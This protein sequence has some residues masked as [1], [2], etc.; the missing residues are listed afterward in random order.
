[1]YKRIITSILVI[2]LILMS[3]TTAYATPPAHPHIGSGT[4]ADGGFYFQYY[5]SSGTWKDLNTPPH[6]VIETSEVA[7]CVDHKADSPSGNETYSAFNPQSLY[8]PTTYYGLLAILKAGYPYK[9][10]GLSAIQARYA[11]ANAIR[12]WL[13][14]SAGIGYN[15][16]NL[17]RG[18]VRPKSGQQP[19]YDFMVALVD[20]AR[21][22]EQPVFSI[23]TNP[24]NIK[25]SYQGNQLLGQFKIVFSNINGYYSID[26]SKLPSGVTISGYTGNNGDVLTISAPISYAGRTVALNNIFE[27]HDTRA[28]SNMYWF[29]PNGNEQPVLVPVTDTTKPVVSGSMIF[30]SDALGYIEIIKT[31]ADSGT[32]LIGAVFKILNSSGNEVARLTTNAQGYAKSSGLP[33][34]TYKLQEVTAPAS[35]L[36][37]TTVHGN[38]SVTS[39]NT[40]TVN[41]TNE[42]P[43]GIIRIT[44]TNGNADMGDYSLEGA[45]FSISNARKTVVE[46]ITTDAQGHANSSEL[47][48]GIYT[49]KEIGAPYGFTLNNTEFTASL[50]YESPTTAIVYDDINV[51]EQPQSGNIRITKV[52]ANP[53]MGDYPLAGAVFEVRDDDEDTVAEITTDSNG[54][55][56]TGYL[57]LGEY[58][59]IETAAPFGYILNDEV[60]TAELSY[61]GQTVNVVYGDIEVNELPQTGTITITKRDSETG[62]V[63]QGDASLNSAIFD[64]YNSDGERVEK[65]DCGDTYKATSQPL[66]L[67]TYMIKEVQAPAGYLLNDTAYSIEIVYS[68]QNVDVNHKSYI[69]SNDVIK[70][71]IA[72]TKFADVALAEWNTDNPKPPLENVEFEIRLKSTGDLVDTLT[73]DSDGKAL[74]IMLPYGTYSVTETRT[75]LGFIVCDHFEVSIEENRKVYSYIVENEVYKSKVK[76]IKVDS[77]TGET[78]P[79]AGTEFQIRDASGDLIVQTVTYPQEKQIGTFITDETGTLTLPEPLIFGDYT[80]HEVKAPYGYWLDETPLAFSIDDSGEDLVTIEFSDEIIQKRIRIIKTDARDDERILAGA[81]F[82]VYK[83][84]DLV[85]TITANENGYAETKLL[86]VGEYKV[87]E[88]EAPVGFVLED[89]SFKV[90]INNDDTMVYTFEC[91]NNPTE[92]TITKTDISDGTL[93]P[94]AHI[95]LYDVNE[96]LV[97]EGDTDENGELLIFELP[98]GKYTFKETIAPVGYVLN[99]KVFEFEILE[100]GDIVGAT[101]IENITTEVTLSKFDLVDGRPVANA[102]IEILNEDGQIVFTDK[103]DQNGEITVTHLL[104][105]T[106]TFRE[107]QAPD[108]YIL[109]VEEVKFSIDEYGDITGETEM[110]NSPTMLEINKVIYETNE[111]LTGAGFRVKNFLGLNTLHFIESED[112]SY[113]FYKDGDI[114]E[115]MVDENGQAIIYGLPL[116][117]YWLEEATVPE[118]YYPTAPVKVTIGG[119][120]N[121]EVPYEA[122]IPNSVFEKLGLDRDK[123]NVPIAIGATALIIGCTTVMVLKRRKKRRNK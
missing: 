93:L 73:T 78:I 62:D 100:N 81:V 98:V 41:L 36:L 83:G 61:A 11:T 85:D 27:A 122:V 23:S 18:Y 52:N 45:Q 97:Y 95:E 58:S 5:G 31:D 42:Q 114:T 68:N 2:I 51:A 38:I 28:T 109:S 66:P 50:T 32:K 94:D 21:N 92:V 26:N 14:E 22:N 1:M 107:T 24:S 113:H 35:Y 63:S 44:K 60:F 75:T 29:E 70:G 25:L 13:S 103:T 43:K 53:E 116:G 119:T 37:D 48:L 55:A 99:E 49:V 115:I 46:T 30:N 56:E 10:G 6:W 87:V 106:Y 110:T 40:T 67:G 118:G 16:M 82:E 88:V 7:Y 79:I 54:Y 80:L 69:I 91:E 90:A 8:S 72:I 20:K 64:I 86:T 33:A 71:Q 104:V 84:S 4:N 117:N 89:V 112:G 120:N 111:P 17:S 47:P 34:G 15:F 123:Y 57:P 76:I 108:G 101:N 3:F 65:L 96:E 19:T 77:E 12:A 121:I 39:N 74:S 59:V 102:T 105:G 9:T